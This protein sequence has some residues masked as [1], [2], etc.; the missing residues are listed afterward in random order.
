SHF[1]L[2]DSDGFWLSRTPD[3]F[4]R[5]WGAD[6]VRAA[7]W[8]K[9]RSRQT[10]AIFLHLN[11]HL[12][13]ISEQARVEGSK[14]ILRRLSEPQLVDLP[15]IVTGDF[16]CSP[17]V[18]EHDDSVPI[19]YTDESYRLFLEAGFTDTYLAAGNLDSDGSNT[20]HAFEGSQYSPQRHHM[21]WRLDWILTRDGTAH[22]ETLSSIIVRDAIPPL[23]PSDHYP[24]LTDLRLNQ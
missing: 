6:S 11:T 13:H 15:V 10:G 5:D 22:F 1:E 7:V 12:D 23:Y 20:F 14:L 4:G 19:R 9:L 21:G 3:R 24:V 16:N 2:L 8:A 18:P 17:W